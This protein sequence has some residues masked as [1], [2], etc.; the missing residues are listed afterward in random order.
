MSYQ[1]RLILLNLLDVLIVSGAITLAYFLRFDFLIQSDYF[2]SLPLV[3][4]SHIV[5]TMIIFNRANMYRRMWQYA[6]VGELVSLVKAATV[7]E[8]VFALLAVT[9]HTHFSW[10]V[11]PRSIYLLYWLLM[12]LFV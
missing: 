10:F 7:T 6:S 3:I 2:K 12:I 1:K 4:A 11:V 5:I 8:V 9:V